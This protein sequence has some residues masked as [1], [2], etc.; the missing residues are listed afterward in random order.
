MATTEFTGSVT[1]NKK[2]WN[3]GRCDRRRLFQCVIFRHCV[4]YL[5]QRFVTC[6]LK[7]W[8]LHEYFVCLLDCFYFRLPSIW[9]LLFSKK[10]H[11]SPFRSG[12]LPAGSNLGKRFYACNDFL[13][14]PRGKFQ[15]FHNA[16]VF[17][18]KRNFHFSVYVCTNTYIHTCTYNMYMHEFIV[19]QAYNLR[20]L[21][22]DVGE[23]GCQIFL[24]TIYQHVGKD[25]KLRKH[26]PYI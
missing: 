16:Q 24:M 15:E 19:C 21:L 11:L 8:P 17:S 22:E 3:N 6:L 7:L 4:P 18:S 26:I 2:A 20:P 13:N 5:V 1:T 10:C 12:I 23:Q 9:F 14:R 25:T